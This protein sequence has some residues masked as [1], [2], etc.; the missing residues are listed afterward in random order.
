M[1]GWSR[2]FEEILVVLVKDFCLW[3]W[4]FYCEFGFGNRRICLYF[5]F[6]IWEMGTRFYFIRYEVFR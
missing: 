5:D 4:E 3:S 2:F 6:F 1:K